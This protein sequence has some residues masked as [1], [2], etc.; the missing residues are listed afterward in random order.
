MPFSFCSINALEPTA[1]L[2]LACLTAVLRQS[3]D[4][5]RAAK[6]CR[7][8]IAS[9]EGT[10]HARTVA[11]GMLG[12][13][14]GLRGQTR[15]ARPLLLESVTLARRI[16]LDPRDDAGRAAPYVWPAEVFIECAGRSHTLRTRP[17]KGAPSNPF[18]WAEVCE[19]FQ[20]YTASVV[21][22]S[23]ARAL[24]DLVGRLEQVTDMADVAE[25]VARA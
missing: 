12:S 17:H 11:T 21:K 8:V 4:W 5:D 19:K 14:L 20:R 25:L 13:I 23:Q 10:L 6:L 7:E 1:Q 24:I 9:T 16:E 2:C 15:Q 3:G 18:S 22:V